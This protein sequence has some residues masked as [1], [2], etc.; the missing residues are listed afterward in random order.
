MSIHTLD[1]LIEAVTNAVVHARRVSE[2]QHL[3][4]LT[5]FFDLKD[6]VRVAKTAKVVVPS[7]SGDG[8]PL[9]EVDVPLITLVPLNSLLLSDIE[10]EFEAYLSSL[11]GEADNVKKKSLRMD[12]GGRGVVGQKKNNVKVKVC[13]KGTDPPEGLVKVNDQILKYLP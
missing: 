3:A 2:R 1:D 13:M 9:V 6:G 7:P 8:D 11:D 10:F 5:S 4:S 12:V